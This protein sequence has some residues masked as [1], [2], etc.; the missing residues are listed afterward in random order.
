MSDQPQALERSALERKDRSE[1]MTI[2]TAMG[3][4]PGSRTKKA[5]IIDM[6]FE[7]AGITP[8]A[9]ADDAPAAEVPEQTMLDTEVPATD[10]PAADDAAA[11]ATAE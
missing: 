10:A 5:D 1:L 2:A 8:A 11:E 6:I 4:K 3:G 7:L 9:P